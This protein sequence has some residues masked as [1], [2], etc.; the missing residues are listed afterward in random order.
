MAQVISPHIWYPVGFPGP[1]YDLRLATNW[2]QD[3]NIPNLMRV[4]F[5]GATVPVVDF[6]AVEFI[7]AKQNSLANGG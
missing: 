6:D 1:A 4:R 2:I 3:Q 5:E 7:A